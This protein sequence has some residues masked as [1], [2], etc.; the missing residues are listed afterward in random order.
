LNAVEKAAGLEDGSVTIPTSDLSLESLQTYI[1]TFNLPDTDLKEV[2]SLIYKAK[3]SIISNTTGSTPQIQLQLPKLPLPEDL[4]LSVSLP[5]VTTSSLSAVAQKM[6]EQDLHPHWGYD[7]AKQVVSS[8]LADSPALEQVSMYL[9]KAQALLLDQG[10]GGSQAFD[11]MKSLLDKAQSVLLASVSEGL[12]IVKNGISD[13]IPS[14]LTQIVVDALQSI[15]TMLASVNIVHLLPD[16]HVILSSQLAALQEYLVAVGARGYSLETLAPTIAI[17]TALI[18]VSSRAATIQPSNTDNNDALTTEYN[19]NVSEQYWQRRPVA[20]QARSLQFASEALGFGLGLLTDLLQGKHNSPVRAVQ[21]RQAIERLGSASIKIAQA[22]STRVD[23][24]DEY[25]LREIQKLQDRVPTF[26]DAVAYDCIAKA[27]K[28]DDLTRV[29]SSLTTSPVAAA[30]LGQVYKGTLRPEFGGGVVAIKVRRP[31]VLS[32][33]ALDIYLMRSLS[34]A[35]NDVLQLDWASLIDEWAARFFEE[36]AYEREAANAVRFAKDVEEQDLV[37]IVV[38]KVVLAVDDVLVSEWIDGERLSESTASDVR[39]LCNT[40]LAAY[41]AQLC[42]TGFLHS[43]PHEGNLLRTPDGKIAVLDYGLMTEIQEEYSLT[44]LEYIAHLSIEDW[45]SVADDLTRLGFTKPGAPSLKDSG[46][47]PT[48]GSILRQLSEGGGA[49]KVDIN[50]V[51]QELDL[52]ADSYPF[53]QVPPYFTLILRCFSVIEGIALKADPDYSIVKECFPYLSRRLLTDDSPRARKALRT[54]LFGD[55]EHIDMNR[56]E[57]LATGFFDYTVEGIPN[58]NSNRSDVEGVVANDNEPILTPA[59]KDALQV[60]FSNEKSYVQELFVEEAAAAADAAARAFA[61]TAVQALL[62]SPAAAVSMGM[63]EA[64]GP[65]RPLVL[66]LMTPLEIAQRFVVPAVE[67]QEGD[68]QALETLD[69][70]EKILQKGMPMP[71][72]PSTTSSS[73]GFNLQKSVRLAQELT[74]VPGLLPGIAK[75]G[76]MFAQKLFSRASQRVTKDIRGVM[77]DDIV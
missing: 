77:S 62:R 6:Q 51:L 31:D 3:E 24:L 46:L 50:K 33:V 13:S 42:D 60:I 1:S 67:L 47:V 57:K 17:T 23:I 9:A 27:Y 59:A 15:Q 56:L 69:R 53:F 28:V 43:D 70:M 41:L 30:S 74:A 14:N 49:A 21:L 63:I 26:D 39:E 68:I 7:M 45:D 71:M 4:S 16:A 29:F 58:S 12:M 32:S 55:G 40:L 75:T 18:A 64:L 48:L 37:G 8:T 61:S 35:M 73:A 34:I 2:E 20:V 36:M 52:L 38:P 11:D 22:L 19:V 72:S 10:L 25:Y 65:W 5:E 44:L 66:P 76:E 54:L